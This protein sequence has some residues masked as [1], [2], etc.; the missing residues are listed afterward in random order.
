MRMG[1]LAA[2]AAA[3]LMAPEDIAMLRAELAA[4]D[5]PAKQPDTTPPDA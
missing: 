2:F 1:I 5:R 4:T 3:A